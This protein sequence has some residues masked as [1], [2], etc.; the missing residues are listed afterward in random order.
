MNLT[1]NKLTIE[2]FA[3]FKKQ[4]FEF[5]GQDARVYGANGTG[6]TTT[7]TALQWLLF[8]KGLDG[9]T[10]SFNP[11]PLKENNEE[12]Y[13]LIPTVEVELNKDGKT[14]KIRKESHPKYTKNQSNNRKEYSRSRRKKQYIN[15][16]SLKV[17]DFQSRIAELVDEDVFKLITNPAAFNDL[18]WKKQRE[19]LF[20]IAD[21]ID[22]EDII[23]TNKDFKDLKDILGDHDIEVKTKILNDKIKQIRKDIEDIPV[24]INQTE[25]NKQDVPEHDEERYNT[26]KQQI[27]QLGNERVDI[28]NGKAEI[29]LRNQLADKQAE[30]NRLEDN[31]DANNEGR[32]HAATN[33]LSV[34]NGTVANLET[35]IRNN[36]QQIEYESKRRQ[37]L[38]SEYHNFKEKEEE[39]R[40]RQFQ[41]STDNVCSCCGQALPPEQVEEVNKKALAKFNKQQSEDLENLKQKTEKILSDGKEIKPLIEKLENENNDLQIKVNEAKEKVQ[42]IQNRIDKLKAG[43]VDIT[44]T[45]EYKS[46]LNDINEINQKRKDIKTT[47]SDKVAKIDERINEL[48][49]EK[50][51]FENAKAIESSN[52]HLDEVIKDLRN[53][54]D[55]LLDKK[56]DYE[57]QLYILK[58]FTTT[59]VKMLTEN[60]NKKFKMANFKL[61]NHQVNGEIKETCVCTVDGVEYNGGLN[62][63]ARINVGLDIIN[64]LSTHYGITAPIFIDNAES[65]T[66]IIPT[67]AQQIQLVV[68]GQDKTLRMETI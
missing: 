42:R 37:A 41:P 25:S 26:V 40:A 24:R 51:A 59:K 58:E 12:D 4:T 57:H 52:E 19:L 23:K 56:E 63:A 48:T 54:E 34:E 14:L 62:N 20:E 27:E 3:G 8:D 10:K 1:I 35:K 18:E 9:S 36:K 11:V 53:E 66:D 60:I 43:N 5:N 22:D 33:E 28:Q 15:D 50:V 6:K 13:E 30:L 31:H 64:T 17:K 7:A 29:D 44:Q 61:F 32:I 67:E 65:V 49:Q 68:S 21:Q 47:I 16:E 46:I 2:N 55:Q 39:V 38:L 45:D